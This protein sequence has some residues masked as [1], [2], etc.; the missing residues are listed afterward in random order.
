MA[1]NVKD[2]CRTCEPANGMDISWFALCEKYGSKKY[3]EF[4]VKMQGKKVRP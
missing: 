1:T 3:A 4:T 2:C